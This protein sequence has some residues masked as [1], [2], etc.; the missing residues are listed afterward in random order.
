MIAHCISGHSG[1]ARP[2]HMPWSWRADESPLNDLDD[3]EE[4]IA[5]LDGDVADAL[6]ELLDERAPLADPGTP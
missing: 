3:A 4:D 6:A 5:E 2:L 1:L